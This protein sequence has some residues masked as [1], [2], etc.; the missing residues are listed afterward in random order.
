M[1]Q[2]Q[3]LDAE[4]RLVEYFWGQDSIY[5]FVLSPDRLAV[6]TV[7]K[8]SLFERQV[9]QLRGAIIERNYDLYTEAYWLYQYLLQ[10]V[11]S[12]LT[13]SHLI[14]IPDG[15]LSYV[16]FEALLTHVATATAGLKDY[17]YVHFATHGLVNESKP[18]LSG[19][20]LAQGNQSFEDGILYLGE[21]YNL[22]LNADLVVLSA[23]KTGLGKI[24]RGEGLIGLTRGFL[25]AGANNLLVSL[26]Q[27]NDVSSSN[28]IVDFYQQLLEG[29]SKSGALREA[30]LRLLESHT[31]YAKPY[32]WAPFV[33]VGK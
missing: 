13:A 20:I 25:Y 27:V 18:E 15:S 26:W 14:I 4:A 5:I 23:Y 1:I 28:L 24:A 22:N 32:Y 29:Q 21:I 17:R 8:D 30:K 33:L 7:R 19:L 6:T 11:E 16:P 3:I 9:S 2:E 10:P 12:H 31:K